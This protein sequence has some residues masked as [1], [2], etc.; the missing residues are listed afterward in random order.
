[1]IGELMTMFGKIARRVATGV[2][3]AALTGGL[4][5]VAAP[6]NADTTLTVNVECGG[7]GANLLECHATPSGGVAPYRYSWTRSSTRTDDAFVGCNPGQFG[8]GVGTGT[9]TVTDAAG[10]RV[11]QTSA[12]A[13]CLGGPF[14]A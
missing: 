5:M 3:V 13:L 12:P 10:T 8:G 6:A 7:V 11:T 9:V 2:G 1:M 4:L 14:I